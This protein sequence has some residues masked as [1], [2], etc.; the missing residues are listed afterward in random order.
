MWLR[1]FLSKDLPCC[2]TMIYGYNS[3]LSS[4]GISK[5][6]DY[7]REFMEELKKSC[8]G[9]VSI[10]TSLPLPVWCSIYDSTPSA[11]VALPYNLSERL[12]AKDAPTISYLFNNCD[13]IGKTT[14][15]VSYRSQLWRYYS[16]PRKSLYY[17]AVKHS[18]NWQRSASSKRPRLMKTT[19]QRLPPFTKPHTGCFFLVSHTKDSWWTI[20][21][22]S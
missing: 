13:I 8:S 21:R 2:R 14:A 19:T 18:A 4:H 10:T 15:A 5:I 17:P 16:C 6:T 20:F 12:P 9:Q 22:R 11:L 3:K 1:D 7:G